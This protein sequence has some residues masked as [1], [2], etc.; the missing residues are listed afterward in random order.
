MPQKTIRTTWEIRFDRE[1]GDDWPDLPDYGSS[2]RMYRPGTLT[3]TV[4]EQPWAGPEVYHADVH[5]Y[6]VRKDG[7][8]GVSSTDRGWAGQYVT[9]PDDAPEHV[10]PPGWV[11]ELAAQ[12]LADVT[13]APATPADVTARLGR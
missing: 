1:D 4:I 12:A 2:S 5:A 8:L 10:R 13:Q 7:T 6:R 3:V 9:D 11:T